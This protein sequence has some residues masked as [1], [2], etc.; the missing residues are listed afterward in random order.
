MV[1]TAGEDMGLV[2]EVA[3][4]NKERDAHIAEVLTAA[5]DSWNAIDETKKGG[6]TVG[7]YVLTK[8]KA[9]GY[10]IRT[11]PGSVLDDSE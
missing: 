3:G 9:A 4:H 10:E 5:V 2:R 1:R 7:L 11:R 8:V 6:G